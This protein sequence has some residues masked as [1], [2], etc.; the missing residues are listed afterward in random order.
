MTKSIPKTPPP[1]TE[2]CRKIGIT[3]R[4]LMDLGRS[5]PQTI[6]KAL[7]IATDIVQEF[8]VHH[9]LRGDYNSQFA[10]F[11]A[12]NFTDMKDESEVNSNVRVSFAQRLKAIETEGEPLVAPDR[13]KMGEFRQAAKKVFL[14]PAKLEQQ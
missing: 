11:V 9:G 14:N 5:F 12:K 7:Q 2:F 4:E 10:I 6:G 3:K 1:I 13:V 8:L